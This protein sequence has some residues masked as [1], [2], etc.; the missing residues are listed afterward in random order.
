MPDDT[1]RA[2]YEEVCRSHD[3]IADFRAKLLAL[4]PTV[5]GAG[6][7][8]LIEGKAADSASV[9]HWLAIG[10]FGILVTMGL[11]FYELRGIQKCN[12]LIVC[13][14]ELEK[15][16]SLDLWQFGTFNM[17]QGAV[18]GGVVGA[19][20]ATLVIYPAVIGAWG[21]ITGVGLADIVGL[22]AWGWL[23]FGAASGFALGFRLLGQSIIAQQWESL[24]S[25]LEEITAKR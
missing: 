2:L 19:T 15:K 3:G 6:L 20:G 16:L 9:Q 11:F 25:K 17:R 13:A 22:D 8:L 4:L 5:S 23:A 18:F 14:Q 10:I 12:Y 7:F 24:R 21:Y 1:A